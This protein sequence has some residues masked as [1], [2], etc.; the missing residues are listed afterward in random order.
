MEEEDE[1]ALRKEIACAAFGVARAAVCDCLAQL[2]H[3]SRHRR[4]RGRGGLV[5]RVR[6]PVSVA[7]VAEILEMSQESVERCWR[8]AWGA[9]C[10]SCRPF[11]NW[12]VRELALS[13]LIVCVWV[14]VV[15]SQRRVFGVFNL[16]R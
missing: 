4:G 6:N 3:E 11:G 9:S 1:V 14:W 2:Y 15:P 7:W 13:F 12:N 16:M 8:G 5:R 10:G